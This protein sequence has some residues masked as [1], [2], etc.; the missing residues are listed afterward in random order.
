LADHRRLVNGVFEALDRKLFL[1]S[2]SWTLL[3]SF[4]EERVKQERAASNDAITNK[5][6]TL[7]Y[8]D[9]NNLHH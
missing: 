5:K 4:F 8:K 1:S 7:I 6:L 3:Y 2:S 9:A